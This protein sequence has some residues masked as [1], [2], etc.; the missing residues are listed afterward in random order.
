MKRRK[1][2]KQIKKWLELKFATTFD[3]NFNVIY[4]PKP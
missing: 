2:P 3:R 1:G 4:N